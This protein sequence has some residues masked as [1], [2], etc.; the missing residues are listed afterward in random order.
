MEDR[1]PLD[2]LDGAF[3]TRLRPFEVFSNNVSTGEVEA[4]LEAEGYEPSEVR[5]GV[6]RDTRE[7]MVSVIN[8]KLRESALTGGS[9]QQVSSPGGRSFISVTAPDRGREELIGLLEERGVVRVYAVHDNTENGSYV[10]EQV[11]SQGDFAGIGAAQRSE[12]QGTHVP[13]TVKQSVAERYAND[14]VEA[15][16]GSGSTCR[17]SVYDP[18]TSRT[19]GRRL[20]DTERRAGVPSVTTPRKTTTNVEFANN[21]SYHATR[22]CLKRPTGLDSGRRLPAG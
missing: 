8:D 14:M 15:G 7:N 20:D 10:R 12:T 16:F 22:I 17:D 2:P 6:T 3:R 11:L 1:L 21:R 5:P 9:V 4:A 13:V 18:R 19:T